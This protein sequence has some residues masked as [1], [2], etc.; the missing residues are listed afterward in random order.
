[1]LP[2]CG[3]TAP[4]V[5]GLKCRAGRNAL[6]SLYLRMFICTMTAPSPALTTWFGAGRLSSLTFESFG[7]MDEAVD[8]YNK[9]Q[10][11]GSIG[12]T[13]L[14]QVYFYE[15]YSC[16]AARILCRG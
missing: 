10:N 8:P 16:K 7:S 6:F 11:N 3:C 4:D 15:C 9:R 2:G 1:M 12:D 5:S 14:I 13:A